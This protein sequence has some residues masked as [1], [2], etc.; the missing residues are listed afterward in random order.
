MFLG[1]TLAGG[2]SSVMLSAGVERGTAYTTVFVAAGV[3]QLA[4]VAVA[5]SAG[6][7]LVTEAA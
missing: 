2:I 1:S 3:V 6:R 7:R 5:L 4:S